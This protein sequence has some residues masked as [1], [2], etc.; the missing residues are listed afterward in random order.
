MILEIN[1]KDIIK[2]MITDPDEKIEAMFLEL[3]LKLSESQFKKYKNKIQ[4]TD[5]TPAVF[6]RHQE[7]MTVK[8][9][10]RFNGQWALFP[11]LIRRLDLAELNP[12]LAESKYFIDKH[13]VAKWIGL[14]QLLDMSKNHILLST[15]P[16]M[17][18]KIIRAH[19]G[20]YSDPDTVHIQPIKQSLAADAEPYVMADQ[21][22]EFLSVAATQEHSTQDIVETYIRGQRIPDTIFN[23]VTFKGGDPEQ[24]WDMIRRELV[25][26]MQHVFVR[27]PYVTQGLINTIWIKSWDITLKRFLMESTNER[28]LSQE[29]IDRKGIPECPQLEELLLIYM[30]LPP[31]VH[32]ILLR[33]VNMFETHGIDMTEEKKRIYACPK[34]ADYET[35]AELV[36]SVFAKIPKD[37]I[38][39]YFGVD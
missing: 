2:L 4:I 16:K 10:L 15:C 18:A 23:A 27:I 14:D 32:T 31:A 38:K 1:E 39:N 33:S 28:L 17:V 8:D 6:Q 20:L 25:Y 9:L 34:D 26:A 24:L 36:D 5:V 35:I 21:L 12:H 7:Y 13:A 19:Y 37:F 11:E 30:Q 29:F 3:E 22:I